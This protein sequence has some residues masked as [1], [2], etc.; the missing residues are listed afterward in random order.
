MACNFYRAR[1]APRYVLGHSLELML[2]GIGMCASV[3]LRVYYSR[4]NRSRERRLAAGE[5]LN[6]TA[7]EMGQLGDKSITFKYMI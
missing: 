7:F 3:S 4:A 2:V 6:F 5:G 1:D